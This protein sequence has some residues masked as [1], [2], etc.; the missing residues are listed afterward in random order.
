QAYHYMQVLQKAAYRRTTA[1]ILAHMDYPALAKALGLGY[2]EIGSTADLEAGIN[3]ALAC[4]GPVL[5]RVITD[6]GKRPVRWINA[7]KNRFTQELSPAQKA[8][9][10]AR[11]SS[12]AL[13]PN[14]W[15]D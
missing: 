11:I 8:R 13:Q 15:N 4:D 14:P 10:L 1:T 5:T 3:T 7:T 2:H 6:Y 9:F 12:R